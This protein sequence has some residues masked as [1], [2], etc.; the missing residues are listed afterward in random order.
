M[1]FYFKAKI[2]KVIVT[3]FYQLYSMFR[4]Q[5]KIHVSGILSFFRINVKTTLNF[6]PLL[7]PSSSHVQR[8]CRE[9]DFC[10]GRLLWRGRGP[11]S[12][13]SQRVLQAVQEVPLYFITRETSMVG[14]LRKVNKAK[15]YHIY[16]RSG[17]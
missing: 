8:A 17:F 7:H 10:S 3:K 5:V 15:M 2:I 13:G 11:F 9:T 1:L 6:W 12:L 14:S 16:A 4:D